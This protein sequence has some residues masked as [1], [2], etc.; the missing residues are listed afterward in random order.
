M[1]SLTLEEVTLLWANTK[2]TELQARREMQ[3][4][5]C[6]T[7]VASDPEGFDDGVPRCY[8]SGN[9]IGDWCEPCRQRDV[10]FQQMRV[11]KREARRRFRRV[12]RMALRVLASRPTPVSL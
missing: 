6:E 2:E 10:W 11:F 1:R 9:P 7:H 8:Q 3:K 5:R 4:H 12:Q